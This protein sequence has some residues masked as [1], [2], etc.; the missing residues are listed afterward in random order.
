MFLRRGP[1]T[2]AAVRRLEIK[3][4]VAEVDY[5]VDGH[6]NAI[7]LY[8]ADTEFLAKGKRHVVTLK[9][10]I[11]PRDRFLVVAANNELH[12]TGVV[13]GTTIVS[14]DD[15]GTIVLNITPRVDVD[16]GELDYIVKILVEDL[17]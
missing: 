16:L 12:K 10:S 1:L 9:T 17:L 6:K 2:A 4:G 8:S 14:P 15:D 7:L 11:R 5:R 3:G 13:T